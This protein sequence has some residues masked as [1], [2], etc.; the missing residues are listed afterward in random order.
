MNISFNNIIQGI[1]ITG[2]VCS[3]FL[4]FHNV[5]FK[6]NPFRKIKT[7]EVEL[8]KMIKDLTDNV[9]SNFTETNKRFDTL[10]ACQNETKIDI[11]GLKVVS[12]GL[13][14]EARYYASKRYLKA[15]GNSGIDV[16]ANNFINYYEKKHKDD[17]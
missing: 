15:N 7:K 13:P 1:L 10:E 11:L 16:I 3:A 8:Q 6:F 14:E 12:K 9:L 4:V 2:S 5:D 17:V